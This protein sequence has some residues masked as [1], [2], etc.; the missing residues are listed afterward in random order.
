MRV[1]IQNRVFLVVTDFYAVSM[2]LHPTLDRATVVKKVNRLFDAV[3]CLGQF[4]TI[5]PK[6]RLKQSWMDAD[7]REMICEDFHFAFKVE[8]LEDGEQVAVVYDAVHSL[9]Y[10]E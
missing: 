6:A 3:D 5:Y 8:E 2:N 1:I 9:L 10:T 4:P 7:Y